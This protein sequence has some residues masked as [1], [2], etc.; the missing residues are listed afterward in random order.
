M[1]EWLFNDPTSLAYVIS[2]S[3]KNDQYKYMKKAVYENLCS[4]AEQ[5]L[6]FVQKCNV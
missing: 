4:G 1:N 2:G 3:Y 6:Y 5:N